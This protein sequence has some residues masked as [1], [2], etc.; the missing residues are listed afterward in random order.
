[1][2]LYVA[3]STKLPFYMPYILLTSQ[4]LLSLSAQLPNSHR[5]ALK[6]C[7]P[8]APDFLQPCQ[9]TP[10]LGSLA[11]PSARQE[12]SRAAFEEIT[13]SREWPAAC[14]W[15]GTRGHDLGTDTK[16]GGALRADAALIPV[17]SLM[18]PVGL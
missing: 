13:P 3:P 4:E 17:S 9:S 5:A 11:L 14:L 18:T 15:T 7:H 8:Q 10:G 1:M 16:E 6:V 2:S 12:L